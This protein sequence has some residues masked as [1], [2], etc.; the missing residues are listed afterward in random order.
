M[1][2][3]QQKALGH[4]RN[5]RGEG[6]GREGD[7]FPLSD[8]T[9]HLAYPTNATRY[10]YLSMSTLFVSGFDRRPYRN[11]YGRAQPTIPYLSINDTLV[12]TYRYCSLNDSDWRV[13]GHIS[14]RCT[15]RARSLRS[16]APAGPCEPGAPVALQPILAAM[17]GGLPLRLDRRAHV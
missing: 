12:K 4:R 13:A 11:A 15:H 14:Q 6:R 7:E 16:A 1:K 3:T 9:W 5:L 2:I 17:Q 10:R 8:A